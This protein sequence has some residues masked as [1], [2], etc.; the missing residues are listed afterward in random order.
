MHG[1]FMKGLE[2]GH[3]MFQSALLVH[4]RDVWMRGKNGALGQRV[5]SSQG[6]EWAVRSEISECTV[7]MHSTYLVLIN[8]CFDLG[9]L[10]IRHGNLEICTVTPEMSERHSPSLIKYTG[11]KQLHIGA[12]KARVDYAPCLRRTS[13]VRGS[14]RSY[15]L[16]SEG[17]SGPS[18]VPPFASG[19]A[20][21]Q[22]IPG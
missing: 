1:Q 15:S 19:L 8:P 20:Q 21:Y 9:S 17:S 16:G 11:I 5:L 22:P 3:A 10:S 2:R 4:G 12:L 18:M 13:S 14:V 7:R 6:S